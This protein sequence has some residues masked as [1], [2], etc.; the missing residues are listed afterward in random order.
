MEVYRS[1]NTI[2]FITLKLIKLFG[3]GWRFCNEFTQL[4]SLHISAFGN[5]NISSPLTSI[6]RL[7]H[8]L[9]Q[10]DMS[11]TCDQT[12]ESSVW[13][14]DRVKQNTIE[15]TR[16]NRTC[17]TI[18]GRKN[19]R[20]GSSWVKVKRSPWG[21][22]SVQIESTCWSLGSQ[23]KRFCS[24]LAQWLYWHIIHQPQ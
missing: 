10:I 12:L 15:M 24:V 17:F 5:W 22:G 4:L 13:S 11:I 21:A 9:L 19:V 14:L 2:F 1:D 16:T 6:R 20:H 23:L 18:L 3:N 7:L 8:H